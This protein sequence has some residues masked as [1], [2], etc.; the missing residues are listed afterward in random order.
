MSDYQKA[1]SAATAVISNS[2]YNL[3]S[4]SGVFLTSSTEAIWQLETPSNST[5]DTPDGFYFVLQGAPIDAT[6]QGTSLS[7]QLLS[8][9]EQG[10][11]R[12]ADWV[13]SYSSGGTTWYFPYKYKNNTYQG[14]E[15]VTVLRLAEQY[16]IRAEA[17]AEENNLSGAIADLNVIRTRANLPPTTASTQSGL[18]AAILHERQIEF[19]TE[20]GHR[21]FDLNRTGNTTTVMSVVAP[22]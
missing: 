10:D 11:L 21:W 13:G 2:D 20:W 12:F 8:S 3:G 4:L 1:D 15:Y 16:L 5:Y 14:Q 9:F 17:R 18:L 7:P 19:F 6:Y 22:T